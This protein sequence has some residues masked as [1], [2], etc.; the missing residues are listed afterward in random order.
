M[1]DKATVANGY[2]E[3]QHCKYSG[4]DLRPTEDSNVMILGA[5][6]GNIG[7]E[8]YK[9]LV[10]FDFYKNVCM[11]DD[12]VEDGVL[13]FNL[14]TAWPELEHMYKDT[15]ALIMCQGRTHLDWIENQ[16][17]GAIY[18][19]LVDSLYT[20]MLQTQSFVQ[21]SIGRPYKK[22]IIYIGSMAYRQILNGSSI[23]CAA[24]AGLNMFAR[25]MAWELAPK[26]YDVYVLHPG[27]VA[28]SPMAE[29]TINQLCRYR[30]ITRQEAETY[31]NTGNPRT[32][33]LTK[34]DIAVLVEEILDN[35]MMY[36]AGNPID[37]T[38]G[39]R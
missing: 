21:A 36:A 27:N 14:R 3:T 22:Q 19:Q 28:D 24:K 8:I 32:T 35:K 6:T 37:L 10:D 31:W 33:I 38:G 16:D 15:D 11:V 17:S 9:Y 34:H 25:C 30:G 2:I 29:S 23:Y 20:H 12:V 18:S 5:H 13:N 39:Q 1:R 7:G 4:L 26:G